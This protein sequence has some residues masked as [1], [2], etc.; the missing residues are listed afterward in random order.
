MALEEF[1]SNGWRDFSQRYLGVFG[2]F[3]DLLVQV[4]DVTELRTNFVSKSGVTYHAN[5]DTGVVFKFVPVTKRLF[6]FDDQL[7]LAQR[8]PARQ[9]KRGVHA[10]NTSVRGVRFGEVYEVSF[11]LLEAYTNNKNNNG[12]V[13]ILNDMFA[14]YMGGVYLYNQRIGTLI[15]DKIQL[16]TP[17]FKQEVIDALRINDVKMSV[18][19]E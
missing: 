18:E 12:D 1:T 9:Y 10:Q 19:V 7:V 6:Y 8:V 14:L 17:L 3:K 13:H 16:T 11:D 2:Y 4:S 5:A 15:K